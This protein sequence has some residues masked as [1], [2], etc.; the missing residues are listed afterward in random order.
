MTSSTD[1]TEAESEKRLYIGGLPPNVSPT[2]LLAR[3]TPFGHAHSAE[4]ALD[5]TTNQC[6]G[7]GHVSVKT[8]PKQ[9]NK[10]FTT[11][12]GAKWKGHVL[13]VE[14]ASE[15]W[16]A[17]VSREKMESI[18]PVTEESL[19]D[20]PKKKRR[21]Q[22]KSSVFIS[23]NTHHDKIIEKSI[24]VEH[25]PS[26]SEPLSSIDFSK[27]PGWKTKVGRPVCQVRVRDSKGRLI[28]VDPT[29]YRNITDLRQSFGGNRP[30]KVD[31]L[32][33]GLQE[34]EDKVITASRKRE[35]Q[36][37]LDQEKNGAQEMDLDTI[38]D[39]AR[40]AE[41]KSFKKMAI[42]EHVETKSSPSSTDIFEESETQNIASSNN[43]TVD[44]E[45][46]AGSVEVVEVPELFHPVPL[47]DFTT[48]PTTAANLGSTATS[49]KTTYYSSSEDE[50]SSDAI[51][52]PTQSS[53]HHPRPIGDEIDLKLQTEKSS[54]FGILSSM[55]GKEAS[56]K[57]NNKVDFVSF[58][59]ENE[60]E[61]EAEE[62]AVV[63]MAVDSGDAMDM[64]VDHEDVETSDDGDDDDDDE[65]V[66]DVIEA[67]RMDVDEPVEQVAE[68]VQADAPK[69]LK[70]DKKDQLPLPTAS[71]ASHFMHG[72]VKVNT[73]LR[74]LL[75]GTEQSLPELSNTQNLAENS[76]GFTAAAG[77]FSILSALG[78]D[79]E[80][81]TEELVDKHAEKEVVKT[82][83]S[84]KMFFMH[85]DN[86][87]LSHRYVSVSLPFLPVTERTFTWDIDPSTGPCCSNALRPKRK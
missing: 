4:V 32:T 34:V 36:R 11:Y 7:F 31:D 38:M 2:E 24:R 41:A 46:I 70:K 67:M 47:K 59:E 72:Q 74:S 51:P 56:K 5:A 63:D 19:E 64:N 18:R 82:F 55:F 6:R 50:L 85:I 39:M 20:A 87:E 75:F 43:T 57:G 8:T 9:F 44:S 12:N 28:T 42:P 78:R 40:E 61:V 76:F 69:D 15:D 49:P 33:W 45:S 29:K 37:L 23:S 17:R 25:S 58:G 16:R 22:P 53:L 81:E 14:E 30:R 13:R 83:G 48:T 26:I 71:L 1:P 66:G 3:F 62:E 65:S 79:A 10:L 73:N 80:P 52:I 68:V 54:M 86:V 27:L 84:S 35:V 60:S 21:R 77:S